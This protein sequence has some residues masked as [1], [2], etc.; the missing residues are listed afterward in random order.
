MKRTNLNE[1]TVAQLVDRFIAIGN[2]TV[3]FIDGF[4]RRLTVRD[5]KPMP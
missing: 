5:G 1:M 2:P 4:G 3:T